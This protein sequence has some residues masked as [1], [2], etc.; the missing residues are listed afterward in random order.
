[1]KSVQDMAC[2]M[3]HASESFMSRLFVLPR[4]EDEV[5]ARAA[6]LLVGIVKVMFVALAFFAIATQIMGEWMGFTL[7]A[8]GL[9]INLL[10]LALLREGRVQW[11]SLVYVFMTWVIFTSGAFYYGGI[12]SPAF[13]ALMLVILF[14]NTLLDGRARLMF[15]ALC[16]LSVL[17]LQVAEQME[18]LPVYHRTS[19]VFDG[20]I[21]AS[22]FLITALI[23]HVVRHDLNDVLLR[24]RS[25]EAAVKSVLSDLVNTT[26][27]KTYVDNILRSISDSLIV[28]G[29]DMRIERV[30]QA[31]LDLLGY[32][33]GDLLGATPEP[34][35]EPALIDR[36]QKQQVPVKPVDTTFVTASGTRVPVSFSASLL[37][38]QAGDKQGIVC[39]AQD[40]SERQRTAQEMRRRDEL[41][42][43][44]A[45]NLPD[46]GVL[47]FDRD[48]NL[49]AA[50]GPVLTKADTPTLK[51]GG[52][53]LSE[54]V[55]MDAEDTQTNLQ[56]ALQGE[57]IIIDLPGSADR[58]Y[59]I[60]MLPVT[61]EG[62]EIFAA[63]MLLQDITTIRQVETTLKQHV[64]HL[65]VL[66][67]VDHEVNR[68]LD[69][70]YILRMALD[71][72][73]RI[74]MAQ[75]GAVLLL[76]NAQNVT[77]QQMIG[78]F[79]GDYLRLDFGLIQQVLDFQRPQHQ[80]NLVALPLLSNGQTIGVMLL[81]TPVALTDD[82]LMFMQGLVARVTVAVDNAKLYQITR[83]Q[84][85]ELQTLYERVSQLEQLK[86][87]MIRMAAHDLR[88]PIN[89]AAGFADLM[90]ENGNL[91]AHEQ[92]QATHIHRAAQRMQKI[93][94]DIL[95]LERIE[96]MQD[97]AFQHTFDLR[98][99]VTQV[100][101]THLPQ[102]SEHQF[103]F[104]PPAQALLVRGDSAQIEEA[105]SNLITNAIKYTPVGGQIDVRLSTMDRQVSL[106][107]QDTGYGIPES[108][109]GRLF[110]PF[111][112]ARSRETRQ[113]EG[114]GLGLHLVKNVIE[115]HNGQMIFRSVHGEGSIFG[116]YL[117][118]VEGDETTEL[119]KATHEPT[120]EAQSRFD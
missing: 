88:N 38:G 56:A 63:M 36:L 4:V 106:E 60:H 27:S 118:L 16:I 104:N 49:M 69:V 110:Q 12:S 120:G 35:F 89:V 44:L 10:V 101:K 85:A 45:R 96:M 31:T 66:R 107:V 21:K 71:M 5:Q 48:L 77:R 14:A 37:Y 108:L 19:P 55:R 83:Q 68:K 25:N 61:N 34:L 114:T 39:V 103:C 13:L 40:I 57:H 50:E 92:E 42:R 93:V 62:G 79:S 81:E 105:V 119:A 33:E 24:A 51:R 74:S 46:M 95:S 58:I 82:Q 18:L 112:R 7:I 17:G 65:T 15:F 20:L 2:R 97:D 54:I 98:T 22:V 117:P 29:P 28:L 99:I 53:N 91:P 26:I 67:Q 9:C 100:C 52:H 78:D 72:A 70:L 102:A 94:N 76:D 73:V 90:L 113:I 87:D 8:I 41:Y 30:N 47:L 6:N 32:T 11:A 115:R 80:E 43:T 116:F 109:Q 111:F 84:L 3:K 59:N 75:A 64:A 86:S 1:M 23:L